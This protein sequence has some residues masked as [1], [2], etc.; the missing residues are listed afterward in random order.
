MNQVHGFFVYDKDGNWIV[1]DKDD[2][3]ANINNS[4]REY[5]IYDKTFMDRAI[6]IGAPL[7][8]R[9]TG[10]VV[11]PVSRSISNPDKSFA[12]VVLI[13][14]NIEYF[15]Q[16][17]A[18][19]RLGPNDSIVQALRSGEVISRLPYRESNTALNV[20]KGEIYSK[21]LQQARS[22]V[23]RITSVID[24]VDRIQV[25]QALERYPLVV[26]V[27]L[28]R[29]DVLAP[30]LHEV[31]IYTSG[32]A[33]LLGMLFALGLIVLR[34]M[35]LDR[36][37]QIE[38]KAAYDAVERLALEDGLTGLANRRHFDTMLPIE[39]NRGRRQGYSVGLI[40]LDVDYFKKF[41]DR[42]GHQMGELCLQAVAQVIKQNIR[43]A[44]DL[45]VRYGGE[46]FVILMP[47]TGDTGTY[48]IATSVLEGIRALH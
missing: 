30:S 14:V 32:L 27:G 13:T 16:Y 2:Y 4:D 12:G 9:S 34:Y 45:A 43:R 42:Y 24:G 6:H 36:E 25:Y 40:M 7:R 1:T 47:N 17:Y 26:Q 22:G 20:S 29:Q 41:N 8:S 46:E 33:A 28:S 35:R 23:V 21:Y 38:L 48:T 18:D 5:F 15:N 37:N 10:D 11:V 3:P 39:L 19:F 44:G 31:V